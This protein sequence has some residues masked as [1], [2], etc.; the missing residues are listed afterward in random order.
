MY[1]PGQR[2][3]L[4]YPRCTLVQA[5]PEYV[6][7]S[8]VI[9]QVRDLVT[10]PL[11]PMEYLRR[12]LIRRSRFLIRGIDEDLGAP[13][14]FYLG[15]SA[16]H[17]SAGWLRVAIY[18]PDAAV[19]RPL[20]VIHRPIRPTVSDRIMLARSLVTLQRAQCD[21]LEIRVFADDLRVHGVA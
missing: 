5:A 3:T 4:S 2:I 21:G 12:P 11:T 18:D 9:E 13:R 7:R 16:E 20:E 17:P 19:A 14:Q 1:E 15:S 6:R 10:D 8:I